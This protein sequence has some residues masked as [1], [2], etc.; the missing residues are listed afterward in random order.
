MKKQKKKNAESKSR[1]RRPETASRYFIQRTSKITA[2][3]PFLFSPRFSVSLFA[4]STS[5]YES[6][7]PSASCA[8]ADI[9]CS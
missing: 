3:T 4:R 9:L 5:F 7:S 1:G 2:G 6:A 8:L